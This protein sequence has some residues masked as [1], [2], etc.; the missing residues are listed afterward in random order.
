VI[1]EQIDYNGDNKK[2]FLV[3]LNTQTGEATLT[4]KSPT[5]LSTEGPYRLTKGWAVR[6]I[7]KK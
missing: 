2:D 4:E 6:V 1:K 7:L 5:V 3:T